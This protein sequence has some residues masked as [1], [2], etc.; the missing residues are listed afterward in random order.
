MKMSE[1]VNVG[2]DK[3]VYWVAGFSCMALFFLLLFIASFYVWDEIGQFLGVLEKKMET[4]SIGELKVP[5]SFY[6]VILSIGCPLFVSGFIY[7]L[8]ANEEISGPVAPQLGSKLLLA[9]FIIG[10]FFWTLNFSLIAEMLVIT[11]GVTVLYFIMVPSFWFISWIGRLSEK[12]ASIVWEIFRWALTT[13]VMVLG[14]LM[15][16]LM[17]HPLTSLFILIFTLPG[18]LGLILN[19]IAWDLARRGKSAIRWAISGGVLMLLN[20]LS[21]LI[22]PAIPSIL[23]IVGGIK[24]K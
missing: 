20:P 22:F 6:P 7:I 4:W 24:S 21:I 15:I 5:S 9:S 12:R 11:P 17:I 14:S 8:F 23:C 10:A 1:V 3:R 13:F 2:V 16:S 19:L 18:F